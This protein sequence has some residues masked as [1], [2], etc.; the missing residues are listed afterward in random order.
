MKKEDGFY[1]IP[2]RWLGDAHVIAMDWDCKGMH[3]HLMAIAWQQEQK[4][5]IIDDDKLIRKLLGNPD[6]KDWE[7]RIKPQIFN[8]WKKKILKTEQGEKLHWFQPG[9][10]KT[11]LDINKEDNKV[12]KKTRV[13]K[14]KQEEVIIENCDFEGFDLKT[15][16]KAKPTSTILHETANAEQKSTIWNL[17]VQ[18]VKKQGDSD[19]KA[20]GFIAR[21]IKQ[22]GDKTV[23]EAIAQL[24]LK[25]IPPA[26]THSYLVG[27]LNKHQEA[28]SIKKKGTG[29]G[30]VSL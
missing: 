5:F 13:V 30:N 6:L 26:D 23:A 24:S 1:F 7:E 12:V 22:Y 9:I 17:G 14:K 27:I 4:G 15:L 25:S 19:A 10:I 16:L 20:R 2:K 28:E 8:A 11:T 3:L 21:L 29:R 18:L